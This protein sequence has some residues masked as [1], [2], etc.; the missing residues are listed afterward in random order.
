M[1]IIV[2]PRIYPTLYPSIE[3]FGMIVFLNKMRIVLCL[4]GCQNIDI[5][6]RVRHRVIVQ[7]SQLQSEKPRRQIRE[8]T[9]KYMIT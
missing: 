6:T 7:Y 5:G 2:Q 4:G 9:Y 3:L 8:K 1:Y